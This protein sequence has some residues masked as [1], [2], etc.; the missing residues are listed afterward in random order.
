MPVAHTILPKI[1]VMQDCHLEGLRSSLTAG[2]VTS[3]VEE[4][5][6]ESAASQD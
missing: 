5:K 4:R 6:I 2:I 3:K 1:I